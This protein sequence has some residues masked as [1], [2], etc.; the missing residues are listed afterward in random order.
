LRQSRTAAQGV[1]PAGQAAIDLSGHTLEHKV[2]R[3][4]PRHK[5]ALSETFA[6]LIGA[7]PNWVLS[8]ATAA[9]AVDRLLITL[10]DIAA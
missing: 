9:D 2:V 8:L 7:Q 1:S 3:W 4:V 5:N 6:Q 10:K